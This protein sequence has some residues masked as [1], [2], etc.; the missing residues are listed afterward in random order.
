MNNKEYWIFIDD[1]GKLYQNKRYVVYTAIIF[2]S[3][4]KYL[5]FSGDFWNILKEIN[6]GKEIKGSKFWSRILTKNKIKIISILE[7]HNNIEIFSFIFDKNTL[8][9]K[10][11]NEYETDS[12]LNKGIA[13]LSDNITARLNIYNSKLILKIDEQSRIIFNNENNN[14]INNYLNYPYPKLLSLKNLRIKNI[15]FETDDKHISKK[16]AGIMMADIL[17]NAV[18]RIYN[19]NCLTTYDF[20]SIYGKTDIKNNIFIWPPS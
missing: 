2:K 20:I 7:K 4:Q 6:G 12:I 18:N 19:K 17:A 13:I 5:N 14:S 8:K 10:F 3:H 1:S 9:Y 11:K 15:N 16:C